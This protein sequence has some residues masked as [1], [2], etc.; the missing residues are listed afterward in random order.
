MWFSGRH[1]GPFAAFEPD[2]TYQ[3]LLI[4]AYLVIVVGPALL[5]TLVER[6]A[7]ESTAQL[8]EIFDH[9]SEA[10]FL[11]DVRDPAHP[12]YEALNRRAEDATGYTSAAIRGKTPHDVFPASEADQIL[13][14]YRR[15]LELGQTTSY[16]ETR[17]MAG[18]TRTWHTTLVPIRDE[19]GD[20]PRLVGFARDQTEHLQHEVARAALEAQLRQAQKMEAIGRLAGGLAHDFNNILTAII[21]HG[22]LLAEHL[23]PDAPER[24]GGRRARSRP[25]RVLA[26]AAGADV[27]ASAGTASHAHPAARRARRGDA[28]G[29]RHGA[30]DHRRAAQSGP[31]SAPRAR[32]PDADSPGDDEHHQQRRARHAPRRRRVDRLA[33]HRAWSTRSSRAPTRRWRLELAVCI[34]VSD[35]GHGMD[36]DTLEHVYEPFFTTKPVGEGTGLGLPVVMGIVQN[37]DGGLDIQSARG[38]GTAVRIFLPAAPTEMPVA[39][40]EPSSA[41]PLGKGQHILLVDDEAAVADIG[42]RLLESLG[43]RVSTYTAPERALDALLADP[44]GVDLLFTDLTMPGMTGTALAQHARRRRADL[45]IVIATGVPSAVTS[46]HDEGFTILPKPY[47]RHTLGVAVGGI[48]QPVA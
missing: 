14:N 39:S 35:T 43:Y 9:S 34:T 19:V 23:P 5:L 31:A 36:A 48:F 32:R 2:V 21:G 38:R 27:C 33:R 46:S 30:R 3:V 11:L 47:T 22:E 1:L 20:I 41:T 24:L 44:G 42:A 10:I 15:A 28:A 16:D 4:Q 25:P 12:R 13:A 45:P 26:G 37:H 40:V 17:N 6:E 18:T 29:P 8:R 7:S